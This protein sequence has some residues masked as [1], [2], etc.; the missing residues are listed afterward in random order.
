MPSQKLPTLEELTAFL[1]LSTKTQQLPSKNLLREL[2]GYQNVV[3]NA[4]ALYQK[5]K[6]DLRLPEEVGKL[7]EEGMQDVEHLEAR[8]RLLKQL[9]EATYAQRLE[10]TS[11]C[12]DGLYQLTRRI[13]E[14]SS[15]F[16][17]IFQ[18]AEPILKFMKTFR[19]GRKQKEKND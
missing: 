10:A 1:G 6:G 17:E 15:A 12:M 5:H 13:R 3:D 18:E 9:Y 8:E 2:P 19:P 4:L 14:F 16:P 11:R 7:L